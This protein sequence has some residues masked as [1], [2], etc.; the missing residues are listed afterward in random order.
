M[1]ARQRLLSALRDVEKDMRAP[2]CDVYMNLTGGK[3]SPGTAPADIIAMLGDQLISCVQ[4]EP[5][6]K[7]MIKDGVEEFY[8]CGPMKQLKSMMK[9]IDPD[10]FKA[11]FSIEV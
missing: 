9:R 5:S 4:W 6:M 10:A 11:T 1:P 2:R 7:Q 8:E 3:I